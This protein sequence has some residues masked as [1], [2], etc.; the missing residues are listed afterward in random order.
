[1]V[2]ESGYGQL[3]AGTRGGSR[4]SEEERK[5]REEEKARREAEAKARREAEEREK[6]EKALEQP[7]KGR[8]TVEGEKVTKE[9]YEEARDIARIETSGGRRGRTKEEL[10]EAGAL[11]DLERIKQEE[12]IEKETERIRT[13]EFPERADL[14]LKQTVATATPLIGGAFRATTNVLSDFVLKA[15]PEGVTLPGSTQTFKDAMRENLG[16]MTNEEINALALTEIQKEELKRG[17]TM[18]EQFGQVSEVIPGVSK[19]ADWADIETPRGNAEQVFKDIKAIRK[20]ANKIASDVRYGY[21]EQE[22]GKQ[23]ID[24]LENYVTSK[25]ARLK[26]LI[27]N[28]PSLNFNSDRINSFETDLFAVDNSIFDAKIEVAKG[29][30]FDPSELQIYAKTQEMRE[31]NFDFITED[32]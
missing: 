16:Q 19:L 23:L 15:V 8:Y 9:Q 17:L 31:D 27:I 13:E 21:K 7:E 12:L 4:L 24:E 28:S 6:E 14:D 1:M 32:W 10:I 20:Q 29:K 26:L 18:S 30:I 11:P 2:H 25:K 22:D 3:G 5:R